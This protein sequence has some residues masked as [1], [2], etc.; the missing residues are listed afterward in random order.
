MVGGSGRRRTAW[1]RARPLAPACGSACI[2]CWST[3]VRPYYLSPKFPGWCA[4]TPA[5]STLEISGPRRRAVLSLCRRYA[6]SSQREIRAQFEAF[7]A[8]PA[9]RPRP[10]Q[11]P[12]AYASP[13]DGGAGHHRN[14]ARLRHD[15][16]APALTEPVAALRRA[17]P[18]EHYSAPL[19]RPWIEWLR[20]R[21][22]SAGLFVNDHVFG[23][24]W[25]G[26]MTEDRLL[27]LLPHLPDGVSEIYFH[28]AV[29]RSPRLTAAMPDYRHVEE[30]AALS[31]PAVRAA[32]LLPTRHQA[33]HLQRVSGRSAGRSL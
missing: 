10:C 2:W 15:G 5:N 16:G 6:V 33:R 12:Q 11:R 32:I 13:S 27:R 24:A 9:W 19:Y 20:R 8:R 30:L 17:F 26:Q 14:R 25:S 21:L 3:G 31:S 1:R 7:H 18:D 28:P 29:E 4:G 23:L 22:Q